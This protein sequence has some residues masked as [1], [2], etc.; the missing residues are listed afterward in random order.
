MQSNNSID[1]QHLFD[2]SLQEGNSID[3]VFDLLH[4]DEFFGITD[5]LS[6]YEDLKIGKEAFE[7]DMASENTSPS[8]N[9]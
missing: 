4:E 3:N 8:D 9:D 7:K 6:M 2:A 5:E 1:N